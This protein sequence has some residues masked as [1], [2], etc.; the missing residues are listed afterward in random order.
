[1]VYQKLFRSINEEK[2]NEKWLSCYLLF[3]ESYRAWFLKE[4]HFN[5]PSYL[6]CK[7]ALQTYMPKFVPMWEHLIELSGGDDVDA[8]LLSLYC[9]T[10]YITGCSQAV[11]NRY[12]PILVRNYDY[13]ASLCEGVILKSKWLVILFFTNHSFFSF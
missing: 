7:K 11:W 10:P 5:R 2:P 6:E 3:K 1:M 9:P 8:R 4:G 13:D 12:T